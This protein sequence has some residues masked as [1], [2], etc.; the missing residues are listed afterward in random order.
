[1]I[2]LPAKWLKYSRRFSRSNN[3]STNS[4]KNSTN[5]DIRGLRAGKYPSGS[6]HTPTF[7]P[8]TLIS[9]HTGNLSSPHRRGPRCQTRTS[10]GA[11]TTFPSERCH[12]RAGGDP[13]ANHECPWE[14][15]PTQRTPDSN[16]I[17]RWPF[18][19]LL[20]YG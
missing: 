20:I 7:T 15:T 17:S 5:W 1:M 19:L 2:S 13:V 9:F 8:T 4:K 18:C 10:L 6:P 3:R 12:P 11:F 16:V 14:R